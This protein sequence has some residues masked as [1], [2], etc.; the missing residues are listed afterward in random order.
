MAFS[1]TKR[2]TAK[3]GRFTKEWH[4]ITFTDG[5]TTPAALDTNINKPLYGVASIVVDFGAVNIPIPCVI[6]AASGV[7]IRGSALANGNSAVIELTGY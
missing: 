2:R 6:V 7:T 1:V 5:S 4:T 3:V